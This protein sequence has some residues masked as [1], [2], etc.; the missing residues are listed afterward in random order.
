MY[1][2]KAVSKDAK[3]TIPQVNIVSKRISS[4]GGG[5]GLIN[6]GGLSEGVVFVTGGGG[7]DES[8][9]DGELLGGFTG[10]GLEGGGFA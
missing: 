8:G 1:N 6:G 10:D 7:D 2:D 5:G 4:G 3:P 9:G